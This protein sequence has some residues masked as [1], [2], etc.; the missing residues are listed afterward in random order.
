MLLRKSANVTTRRNSAAYSEKLL[1]F[2]VREFFLCCYASV[3]LEMADI[4]M[5]SIL[6]S[7]FFTTSGDDE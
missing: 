2:T 3:R 7:I 4:V 6:I 1:H 5:Y